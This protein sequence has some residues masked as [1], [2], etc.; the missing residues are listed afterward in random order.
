MVSVP[1]GGALVNEADERAYEHAQRLARRAEGLIGELTRVCPDSQVDPIG[2]RS[3]VAARQALRTAVEVIQHSP[4][5]KHPSEWFEGH[6]A[7]LIE[8]AGKIIWNVELSMYDPREHPERY[9][10]RPA[11]SNLQPPP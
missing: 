1:E 9:R 2:A 8:V 3:N 7:G 6:W 11:D 5:R 10:K 4:V